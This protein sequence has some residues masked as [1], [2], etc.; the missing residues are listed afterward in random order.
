MYQS[1]DEK[2]DIGK[3]YENQC[4]SNEVIETP[5]NKIYVGGTDSGKVDKSIYKYW[6][7]RYLLFSK[8]DDGV[9]LDYG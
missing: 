8:F 7:Q 5:Q 6:Y 2:L 4:E 3:D 1:A 9:M